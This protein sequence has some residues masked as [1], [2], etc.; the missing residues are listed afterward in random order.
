MTARPTRIRAERWIEQEFYLD[1]RP[2]WLQRVLHDPHWHAAAVL[3][4]IAAALV[5]AQAFGVKP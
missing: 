3:T 4:F 2:S 5:I 1:A